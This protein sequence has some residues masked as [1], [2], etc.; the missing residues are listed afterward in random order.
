M[1]KSAVRRRICTSNYTA[2]PYKQQCCADDWLDYIFSHLGR[3]CNARHI[4]LN[5]P[6]EEGLRTKDNSSEVKSRAPSVEQ[7]GGINT[8]RAQPVRTQYWQSRAGSTKSKKIY[9]QINKLKTA[10]SG[11]RM[12]VIGQRGVLALKS[13]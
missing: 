10:A 3:P 11:A 9:D 12:A 13:C 7:G 2:T 5:Q 4:S 1:R 6:Q 8:D